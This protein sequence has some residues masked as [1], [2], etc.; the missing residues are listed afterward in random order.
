MW[1]GNENTI[2]ITNNTTTKSKN[3]PDNRHLCICFMRSL[4]H[5]LTSLGGN[6]VC[7][8][9]YYT[10]ALSSREDQMLLVGYKGRLET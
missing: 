9:L 8:K 3:N 7:R 10:M 5:L 2:K 6:Y 4:R 1:G